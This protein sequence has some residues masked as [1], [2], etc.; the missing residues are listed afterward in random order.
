MFI[1]HKLVN[2]NQN[3]TIYYIIITTI[4]TKTLELLRAQLMLCITGEVE[5]AVEHLSNAVP[6]CGQ[7]QQLLQVLEQTLPPQVFHLLVQKL[8]EVNKVIDDL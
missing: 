8:P 4:I 5:K 1:I 2:L 3:T 6:L 7:P